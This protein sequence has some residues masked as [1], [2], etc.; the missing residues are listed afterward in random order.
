MLRKGENVGMLNIQPLAM[1]SPSH[2]L[3]SSK[4]EERKQYH[5]KNAI[6]TFHNSKHI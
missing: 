6:C 3:S 5:E 4:C 2:S 1:R